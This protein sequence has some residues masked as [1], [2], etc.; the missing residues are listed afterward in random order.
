MVRWPTETRKSNARPGATRA[1]HDFMVV[2]ETKDSPMRWLWAC[3]YHGPSPMQ[4]FLFMDSMWG[5]VP[6]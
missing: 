2:R 6:R 4:E 3:N 5:G 1:D